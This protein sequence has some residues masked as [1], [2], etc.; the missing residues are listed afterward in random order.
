MVLQRGLEPR[1]PCLKGGAPI[2][3]PK[4]RQDGP[5]RVGRAV[6]DQVRVDLQREM[7]RGV[8]G[9]VLHR[10]HVRA[11]ED[12]LR[13][14]GVP[15]LVRRHVEVQADGD[16][17]ILDGVAQGVVLYVRLPVLLLFDVPHGAH[18]HDVP[19]TAEGR[20]A[21][22]LP[23]LI[24]EDKLARAPLLCLLQDGEQLRRDRDLT[25]GGVAFQLLRHDW[26]VLSRP[27]HGALHDQVRRLRLQINTIPLH[28][29]RFLPAQPGIEAERD[30]DLRLCALDRSKELSLLLCGQRDLLLASLAARLQIGAGARLDDPVLRGRGEDPLHRDDDLLLR[31]LREIC[32]GRHDS[33]HVVP[34]HFPD[35]H[36][37]DHRADVIIDSIGIVRPPLG[38]DAGR[39]EGKP[40]G[41]IFIDIRVLP[42][43][44]QL[45]DVVIESV[46]GDGLRGI[47]VEVP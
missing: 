12:Q 37:P 27:G 26:L 34:F 16:L 31:R 39:V 11:G 20:E 30:E 4:G 14:V 44:L 35:E 8:A 33:Q 25:P 9:Q 32:G 13:D 21:H 18:R 6:L 19:E 47:L 2:C 36:V 22:G 41:S 42:A 29:E 17:V 7:R 46:E 24:G 43:L 28:P 23:F 5:D 15:Q 40:L 38:A 3:T 1:T 45:L 10:F